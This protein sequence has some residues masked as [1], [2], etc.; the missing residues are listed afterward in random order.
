[1][2]TSSVTPDTQARP[3]RLRMSG[4]QRRD[5]LLDAA[6]RLVDERGF[7]GLSVESVA[8][9]AGI[10]RPIIYGHFGNL[11]GLIDALLE[12]EARIAREELAGFLPTELA[13][14]PRETLLAGLRGYLEA[15]RANPVTWRLVLM[16][17][18]GAPER[19]RRQITETRGEVLAV[20]A[21]TL[22][23]GLGSGRQMPDPEL[24]AHAISA[25]S[26]SWARLVLTDPGTY[27]TDRILATARWFL[28]EIGIGD[29]A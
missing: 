2:E 27:T 5:Q 29:T 12:R 9:A 10:S 21:N 24:A 13:E 6:R 22:Q 15:V 3:K 4:I 8:Q 28:E 11:D 19:L 16:P 1:M 7:Q 18:E 17:S 25:L 23:P 14:N 20:L 26:D